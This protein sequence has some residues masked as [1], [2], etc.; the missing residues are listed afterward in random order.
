[1]RSL[2]LRRPLSVPF[3]IHSQAGSTTP[4][5]IVSF[6]HIAVEMRGE[7]RGSNS[8]QRLYC[9]GGLCVSRFDN[10]ATDP[11]LTKAGQPVWHLPL[12]SNFKRGF[13]FFWEPEQTGERHILNLTG[14][15]M[16][17]TMLQDV[18]DHHLKPIHDERPR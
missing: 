11:H 17:S 15:L 12:L 8:P 7:G 5:E 16:C 14:M 9:K 3:L 1:M 4:A 2:P 18:L 6:L 13:S 10:W